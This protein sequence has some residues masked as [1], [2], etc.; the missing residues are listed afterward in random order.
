MHDAPFLVMLHLVSS[1]SPPRL[2]LSLQVCTWKYCM[3]GAALFLQVHTTS[4]I[5]WSNL[6]KDIMVPSGVSAVSRASSAT[7]DYNL[8][9]MGKLSVSRKIV[10]KIR[11]WQKRMLEQPN[12]QQSGLYLCL[13][14]MFPLARS[15][16]EF[17]NLDRKLLTSAEKA[18]YLPFII[19]FLAKSSMS[20][21]LLRMST[22]WCVPVNT[23]YLIKS[24]LSRSPFY[25]K[26]PFKMPG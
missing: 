10:R 24:L 23:G 20:I 25:E 4:I 6:L 17:N 7:Q 2:Q 3:N 16:P 18:K 19:E 8:V 22:I 12:Q 5:L 14:S 15:L 13:I 26:S 11:A 9:F 1:I 21:L